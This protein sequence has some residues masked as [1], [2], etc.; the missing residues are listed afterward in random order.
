M[1]SSGHRANILNPCFQHIGIGYIAKE[2]TDYT[3]YWTMDLGATSNA[4]VTPGATATATATRTGTP[5]STGSITPNPTATWTTQPTRTPTNRGGATATHTKTRTPTQ[6]A[7]RRTPTSTLAPG[8]NQYHLEGH[9]IDSESGAGIP[10]AIVE[11]YRW[12]RGIWILVAQ[13]AVGA[14]GSFAFDYSGPDQRFALVERTPSGYTS[15]AADA[16]APGIVETSDRVTFDL[17]TGRATVNT[18]FY[19]ARTPNTPTPTATYTRTAT[20]RATRTATATR[21]QTSTPTLTYTP[22]PTE[23]ATP[24]TTTVHLRQVAGNYQGTQDTYLDAW[25]PTTNHSADREL[26]IRS[27]DVRSTLIR[28]D[29]SEIPSQATITEAALRFYLLGSSNDSQLPVEAY[30][31]LQPWDA[32]QPPS[33]ANNIL[34][35]REASPSARA[36]LSGK[37]VWTSFNV[38]ALTQEW[39]AQPASNLGA[40]LRGVSSVAVEYHMASSEYIPA[41]LRPEL[42]FSYYAGDEQ[43]PNPT[44]TSQA[45]ATSTATAVRPAE[46]MTLREGLDGYTGASDAH[47]D[48]WD[49]T[50]NRGQ[51]RLVIVRSGNTRSALFRFDLSK[52]P[53]GAQVRSATLRLYVEESSNAISM[54]IEVYRLRRAWEENA[55]TWNRASASQA[56]GQAGADDTTSDREAAPA[57]RGMLAQTGSWISLDITDLVSRWLAEPAQNSGVLIKGSGGS[58]VEY[59]FISSDYANENFRPQL[60]VTYTRP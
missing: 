43:Q 55:A 9:V 50:R 17:P 8:R 15:D 1:A 20:S 41:E 60:T 29:L 21:T 10:G 35:A 12:Q 58:A 18:E 30:R 6:T 14:D 32:S 54:S 39:V 33:W 56:W 27:G 42:V 22:T 45:Q 5:T 52:L 23:T 11:L 51:D 53:A 44:P 28:F 3:T 57:A 16:S 19:D 26:V 34:A 59:R 31:L 4:C 25:A 38:T 49:P 37:D 24:K 40:I 7:T 2:G 13:K 48:A 46:T 36:I 47:L